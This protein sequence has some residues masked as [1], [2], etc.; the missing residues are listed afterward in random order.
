MDNQKKYSQAEE[1]L[2]I[3]ERTRL[4]CNTAEELGRMVGFSVTNRNSLL[5]KGGN[6][7]FMKEAIF[8][9]LGYICKERTG[10]DLQSLIEAYLDVDNFIDRYAIR[11]RDKELL[12]QIV[13]IFFGSGVVPEGLDFVT[14]RLTE[15]HIP[16]LVL[17]H[18]GG[19]PR[20]SAKGGDIQNIEEDYARTF[21]ILREY[22][23][24]VFIEELP[25]FAIMEAAVKQ[26][27][28]RR[29]RLHLIYTTT[30]ILYSYGNLSTQQRLSLTNREL[31]ERLADLDVDGIWTEDD[32]FTAFWYFREVVNGYYIYHYTL[33]NE[34]QELAYTKYFAAFYWNDD[35]DIDAIIMHPRSTQYILNGQPI[36]NMFL[37]YQTCEI[38]TDEIIFTPKGERKAW[39][40]VSRL[41]RSSHAKY[42]QSLLDDKTKVKIN[43]NSDTE[44][45]F[46]C[47]LAAITLEHIY[48]PCDNGGYYKIPKSLNDVL[49]DVHFGDNV[50]LIT[51]EGSTFVAFDDKSL[52][53]DVTTKEK[54]R[55]YGIEV[56]KLIT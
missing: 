37:D 9:Q 30:K 48:L 17:M 31:Q 13:D 35:D 56:V 23:K 50:G 44:Y 42:F 2:R 15:L 27:S 32:S 53:Y 34:Q 52:Y 46:C 24:N 26:H 19:L 49:Y 36:P 22:C 39:F 4:F 47:C 33:R 51:F 6:S 11:L 3:I 10:L 16:I 7:T 41:R 45:D 55:E 38:D 1:W 14:A 40:N 8:H 28:D 20:L 18:I 54:M 12:P 43:E 5:R 21:S 29:N 25:T